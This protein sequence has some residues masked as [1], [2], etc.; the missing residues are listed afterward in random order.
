[1]SL[2]N[3]FNVAGSGMSAQNI[4][5]NTTASNLANAESI[6]SSA[7][8]VYRAKQPVF[9]TIMN[10]TMQSTT[11]DYGDSMSLGGVKV[12]AIAETDAPPIQ[13]YEPGNPLANDQGYIFQ[14]NINTVEEM[15]NMMSA[16]RHYQTNVEVANTSKQMLLGTLRLGQ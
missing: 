13:R 5:L 3:I 9:S 15:A 10:E 6:A 2:F 16:S 11:Q 12:Q 4:R 7:D 8:A 14:A 1:M